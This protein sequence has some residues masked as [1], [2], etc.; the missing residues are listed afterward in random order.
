MLKIHIPIKHSEELRSV[1]LSFEDGKVYSNSIWKDGTGG[2]DDKEFVCYGNFIPMEIEKPKGNSIWLRISFLYRSVLD[3]NTIFYRRLLYKL[4]VFSSRS[5]MTKVSRWLNELN[6][7]DPY[8][9]SYKYILSKKISY[10]TLV[11][12]H[13]KIYKIKNT[14]QY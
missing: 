3:T 10:I 14:K 7:K 4:F 5:N 12:N 8:Y 11:R 1:T 2:K 9:G 6:T 13:Y